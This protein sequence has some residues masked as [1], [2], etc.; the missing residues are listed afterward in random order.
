MEKTAQ[1]LDDLM[2]FFL[3]TV[4]VWIGIKA[5][6]DLLMSIIGDL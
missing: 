5:L 2:I 4:T 3:S 6:F 1:F